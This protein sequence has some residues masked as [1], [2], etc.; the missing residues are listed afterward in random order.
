MLQSNLLP[1]S[2][3]LALQGFTRAPAIIKFPLESLE[4]IILG[5]DRVGRTWEWGARPNFIFA[6]EVRIE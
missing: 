2:L 4:L 5:Q 3:L 1:S 6:G